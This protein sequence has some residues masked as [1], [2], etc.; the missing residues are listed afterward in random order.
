MQVLEVMTLLYV[1]LADQLTCP[2]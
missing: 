1:A 2:C